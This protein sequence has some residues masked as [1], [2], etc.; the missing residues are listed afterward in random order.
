M[1]HSGL[2]H[3]Q[4]D[5]TAQP[6]APHRDPGC[7]KCGGK[8]HREERIRATGDGWSRLFNLQRFRFQ[9]RVCTM[10][11]FTELYHR[12]SSTGGNILDLLF[13]A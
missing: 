8:D 3:H 12:D 4:S 10:C 11:G 1:S 5:R 9:A 13:G 6:D 7:S 2:G